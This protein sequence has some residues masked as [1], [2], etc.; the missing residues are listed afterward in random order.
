MIL[1][2]LAD[3]REFVRDPDAVSLEERARSD[4][5][6]LEDLRRADRAGGE[7]GLDTRWDERLLAAAPQ[8]DAGR[9]PLLE[10]DPVH[11]HVGHHGKVR[12]A[13]RRLEESLRR[14]P[15]YATALV[16]LEERRALV[17]AAVEILHLRDARLRH[18]LA[19]R[20][21][22]LPRQSLALDSPLAAGRVHVARTAV[23][24]LG[25]LEDRQHARP[26]PR[27]VAGEAHP[28]VVVATLAAEIEHR[29][30][31]RAAAKDLAAGVEDGAAVQP[32]IGLGTVAPVG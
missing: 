9:P 28:F 2:V 23:V 14:A 27:A 4:A 17:V 8:L 31:R 21:E 5:G 7:N 3:A 26:R 19:E 12:P 6:K 1:Q 16:H 29:V 25:A 15:A 22:H 13:H 10:P 32:G 11:M 18:R 30:D 20:V 24:V